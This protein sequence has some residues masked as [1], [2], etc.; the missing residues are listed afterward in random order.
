MKCLTTLALAA[1]CISAAAFA[2]QQPT[3]NK[4]QAVDWIEQHQSDL[5]MLSDQVWAYAETALREVK[6]SKTLADYAEK[7]GFKVD[8]GVAG[9]PT[10]FVATFGEGKPLIGIMGEYDALPGISQKASTVR[11]PLQPGAAGHGC[12]HNLFGAA[13]LGAATAIKQLIASG[14]LK[15]TVKFF[16]TPAEEAVGGKIY[17]AREGVFKDVDVMLAWHPADRTEADTESSQA[18]VDSIIEFKGKAAHAAF[19][20]WNGRSAVDGAELFTH[21]V[22]MLR[23]HVK[24]T[25]RMHY[26]IVKG[27]DVPNVVPE[28]AKVWLWVRDSKRTGVEDVLT[29]IRDIAKGAGLMAGV[30]SKFTVQTGDY[31]MNVNMT[32]ARLLHSNLAWLGPIQFTPEEN[33]FAK[34][35]QR[36]TT[37]KETGLDGSIR[38]LNEKPGDPPG[39]S[40]DVGDVSWLMPTLHV[41]VATAPKDAPWHAWP[42]VA[43]G[44]MSAGH[45][46]MVYASK[47]LAATMVDLYEQPDVRQA[48]R[49]EFD[50]RTKGQ[51]YKPYIPEGPPPV[52]A[53]IA[54]QFAGNKTSGK[55]E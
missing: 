37:V 25:V 55:A 52:P 3:A 32:G 33:E 11:E 38:P 7:Q 5:T 49:A 4:K 47:V 44:G 39:G 35:I 26:V 6:S 31:E 41:S 53:D 29:R 22:N 19:D 28:Y 42:V 15:G 8:R 13:S 12:G 34:A 1:T 21:G 30:E 24:P 40:T 54:A 18:I 27:G 23:E 10:A 50:E 16:G 43:T 51:V 46:G 17:M 9:M 14:K 45:R 48:I 20:P 36:A 2:A